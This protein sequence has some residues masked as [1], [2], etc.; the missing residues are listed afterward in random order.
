MTTRV[1]VTPPRMSMVFKPYLFTK[2][3]AMLEPAIEQ[4]YIV[5]WT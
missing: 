2:A 5:A 4:K 1:N 3:G